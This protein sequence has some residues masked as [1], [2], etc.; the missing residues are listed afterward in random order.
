M[1]SQIIPVQLF[2]LVVFGATGDLAMRKLLP[3]LY[4]RENDLQMPEGSRIV[5]VARRE[6]TT[7]AYLDLVEAALPQA[8]RRRL[9]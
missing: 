4:W 2:D 7:E 8:R 6:L 9:R 3:A 5:G 1:S